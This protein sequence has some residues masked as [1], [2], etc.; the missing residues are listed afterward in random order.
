MLGR[1]FPGTARRVCPT[2][3]RCAVAGEAGTCWAGI[4]RARALSVDGEGIAGE[5]PGRF[6]CIGVGVRGKKLRGV[7]GLLGRQFLHI[8]MYTQNCTYFFREI[9]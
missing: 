9:K 4:F 3:C 5:G 1:H 6:V 8:Y 2:R 7:R